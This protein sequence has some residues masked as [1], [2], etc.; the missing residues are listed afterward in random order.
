M[1]ANANIKTKNAS[2]VVWELLNNYRT[3]NIFS[4]FRGLKPLE[5]QNKDFFHCFDK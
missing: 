2:T 3:F 1:F 5:E 4:C